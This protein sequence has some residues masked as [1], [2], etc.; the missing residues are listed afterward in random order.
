MFESKVLAQGIPIGFSAS[1]LESDIQHSP[2]MC[3]YKAV[4]AIV[5]ALMSSYESRIMY[6]GNLW[7][8]TNMSIDIRVVTSW[9]CVLYITYFS[10]CQQ[11]I[12]RIVG[13]LP[14]VLHHSTGLDY[15]RQLFDWDNTCERGI[16]YFNGAWCLE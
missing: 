7:N 8:K 15:L 10:T 14:F 13:K 11:C 6:D 3:S 4:S 12:V 2:L 9:I 5:S 16:C 1:N